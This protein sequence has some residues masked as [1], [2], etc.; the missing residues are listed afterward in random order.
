MSTRLKVIS[1]QDC[2][3]WDFSK[4][5]ED[6]VNSKKYFKILKNSLGFEKFFRK[7]IKSMFFT[8]TKSSEFFEKSHLWQS[9]TKIIFS[10][11]DMFYLT[12]LYPISVLISTNLKIN[13]Y[14]MPTR[15]R[16]GYLNMLTTGSK[17]LGSK[18][19]G[20]KC[21]WGQSVLGSKCL[22]GQSVSLDAWGQSV[23]GS[24][25]PQGQS[26]SGSKCPWGQSVL[27]SKCLWGQ[28]VSGVKVSLGSKWVWAL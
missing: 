14:T 7:F 9:W 27:G 3:R 6:L 12:F 4:S 10:L 2:H 26:V 5:S 25:C 17:C 18:C 21:P 24:K 11:V 22:Q 13:Q 20:S 23:M 15:A 8:F 16:R 19:V 28:S 1:V